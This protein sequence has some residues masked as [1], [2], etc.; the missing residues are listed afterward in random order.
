MISR[1]QFAAWDA[2]AIADRV[3]A[4]EVSPVEIVEAALAAMNELDPSLCAFCTP[5]PETARQTA[6]A[7]EV[8][9][10][11]GEPLGPLAG[12]P[13]AVKDLVLTRGIR[14]TFGSSLYADYVPDEDDVAVERLKA[15]DAIVIGK[16]NASEFGYG[17]FGHNLLFPTTRNPWNLKLTP[18]GSSAG[19]AAAVA[20]GVC[21]VALGSD[22]GGSVRLPAAFTGLV[23]L[24]PT[25]GRI[26]LWPSCRDETLPGASGWESIE[27]YGPLVRTVRD[28]ALFLRATSGPD[29]RDRLSLPDEGVDWIGAPQARLPRNLK[30]AYCRRWG[31]TPLDGE[32]GGV[33][34]VAA[35]VFK[36][37]LACEVE[38]TDPPFG[39]LIETDRALIAMETDLSGLRQRIADRGAVVSL[40]LRCV[41]ERDWTAEQFT[42]AVTARKA[43]V[44]AMARFMQDYHLILTP[45]V[46]VAESPIERDG[47]GSIDGVAV[48]D[49]AW[50]PALYPANLTGQPAAS[51]PAGWTSSGLPVGLQIIGRRLD[52][53][54]V[55]AAA[56]AFERVRPWIGRRPVHS[57]WNPSGDGASGYS[58]GP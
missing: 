17:G 16:T 44:N 43:A 20:A 48:A 9:L 10:L 7:L 15:A 18:G 19:S 5:S 32:V 51:V 47:P 53:W 33:V 57:I 25:M 1:Q 34:D 14:T 38:E 31:D 56:G 24:K 3:R 23:G 6:R 49:D 26:P 41:L 36:S 2:S 37:E 29:L 11:R 8:R 55:I 54:L 39:D 4:R 35:R 42:D 40:A 12:V 27:H 21:P 58:S 50:T 52:D 46:P 28:A 22:G 45:T 13:I 30:I